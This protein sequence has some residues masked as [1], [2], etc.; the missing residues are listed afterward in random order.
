MLRNQ[1]PP[2]LPPPRLLQNVPQVILR[3]P[4]QSYEHSGVAPIVIGDEKRLWE[5]ERKPTDGR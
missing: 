2:G 5:S 3:D 4:T 1:P